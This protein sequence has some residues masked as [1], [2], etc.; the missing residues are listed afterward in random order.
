MVEEKKLYPITILG[1]TRIELELFSENKLMIAK[2]LLDL[3]IHEFTRK[4]KIPIKRI[5]GL[6]KLTNQIIS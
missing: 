6:Q 1:P 3:N 5:L 2:D 4:T